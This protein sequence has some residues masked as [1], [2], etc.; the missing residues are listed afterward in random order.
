M[1]NEEKNYTIYI[2]ST[3]QSIPVT[4]EVFKN[5]YRG[6]DSFRKEQ[7]RKGLCVVPSSG[8]LHCDMN[9]HECP[10]VTYHDLSMDAN[11]GDDDENPITLGDLIPD[12]TESIENAIADTAELTAV[13][14][15]IKELMP[16]AI[17]IGKMRI[18]GYTDTQIAEQFG[19]NR[20]TFRSR[21]SKVKATLASEFPD[22]SENF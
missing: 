10:F 18:A 5:Y 22:F 14:E 21:I 13:L 9:C 4:K 12:S 3:K 19:I 16:Q 20:T 1:S 2:C 15:R 17:E 6:I 8:R 11:L 7:Q